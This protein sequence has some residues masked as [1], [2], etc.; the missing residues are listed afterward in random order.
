[1]REPYGAGLAPPLPARVELVDVPFWPQQKYQCGPAALA[2]VLGSAGVSVLPQQLEEQ[3][4]VP[5]RRGSLQ[6]EMLGATRRA[7]IVPYVLEPNSDA[8]LREVAAGHP[9]VVLQNLRFDFLPQWHYAVV[10]GYD[11]AEGTIILRSG[12]DK[13]QV[14]QITDFDRRWAKAQQWAFV[15]LPPDRLPATAR[16]SDFVAAAVAVER[17]APA[18]ASR[19]YETALDAWPDNLLALMALGNIAYR[20]GR[21]DDAEQWYRRA[22]VS[23]PDAADAW[24]NLAQVRYENGRLDE[25]REAASRAVAI[26]GVRRATYE[27]TLAA[28][29]DAL[30]GLP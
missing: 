1:V 18:S 24:N 7:G 23:N 9:V 8:L 4:Y 13:R 25:A 21:L 27:R 5:A 17:V 10:V 6:P 3:V 20:Q 28:I 29:D 22:A 11:L 15:A 12:N 2:T 19:A 16:E 14:L 30:A 26:G